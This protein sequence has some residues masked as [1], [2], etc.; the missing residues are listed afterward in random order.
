PTPAFKA[1]EKTADPLSMYLSDIYTISS[2]LAG[3]PALS[4]P[5]GFSKDNLPLGMQLIGKEF[6]EATLIKLGDAFQRG[7]DF[8]KKIP[9]IETEKKK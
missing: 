4:L 5:C 3:I 8:H 7:T 2:N 1:G 9:E 6:D